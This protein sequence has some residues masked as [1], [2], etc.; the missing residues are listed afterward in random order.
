VLSVT[1]AKAN[2]Y[3]RKHYPVDISAKAQEIV[4]KFGD[5][6]SD[7]VDSTFTREHSTADID[8]SPQLDVL[9]NTHKT[10][11]QQQFLEFPLNQ[12]CMKFYYTIKSVSYSSQVLSTIAMYLDI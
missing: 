10:L 12:V 2:F 11:V 3:D 8:E 7:N 6:E 1:H 5:T 4:E 9:E